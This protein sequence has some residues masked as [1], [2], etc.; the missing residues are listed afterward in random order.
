MQFSNILSAI[1][2]KRYDSEKNQTLESV[3]QFTS[4]GEGD[5]P[6]LSAL[7][8]DGDACNNGL[9]ICAQ[10]INK[11]TSGD[12][13]ETIKSRRYDRER[14]AGI[15]ILIPFVSNIISSDLPKLS[16]LYTD[17]DE[18]NNA[19]RICTKAFDKIS[20]KDLIETIKVRRYDREKTT[21]ICILTPYVFNITSSDLLQLSALYRDGDALNDGLKYCS[22]AINKI[23]SED[24]VNM[25]M[26][27]RFDREKNTCLS[28]LAPFVFNIVST[29]LKKL[30]SVYTDGDAFNAGLRFCT[31][32]IT[33][34]DP[35]DIVEI[36]KHRRYDREKNIGLSIL[37]SSLSCI[38][39]SDLGCL[40]SQ[41]SDDDQKIKAVEILYPKITNIIAQDLIDIVA[42]CRF[43]SSRSKIREIFNKLIRETVKE[44][45]K[46][47]I[48]VPVKE[49]II[50]PIKEQTKEPIGETVVN[51]G[52]V[53]EKKISIIVLLQ[54][55]NHLNDT[56]KINIL[57]QHIGSLDLSEN[58]SICE[59]LI[60][61][62]KSIKSFE[63][64]CEVLAIRPE[65]KDSIIAEA[66]KIESEKL[67][68]SANIM[69]FG[70]SFDKSLFRIN[71]T[72]SIERD[73][74]CV[75]ITRTNS[76]FDIQVYSYEG[77]SVNQTANIN[78]SVVIQRSS[79]KASS[80][81]RNSDGIIISI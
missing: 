26:S 70:T 53:I 33:K 6:K 81:I 46:E 48:K 2:A 19:L 36:V 37:V 49:P 60:K 14:T 56:E 52:A 38:T 61:H 10:V 20:P 43:D 16:A 5:L 39:S 47:S 17:G 73:G 41:Y 72:K 1:A 65:L 25:V 42:N 66:K 51:R 15:S 24:L 8:T 32:A 29:D 54:A 71:A 63:L 67:T 34:V 23:N 44:P 74:V 77:R 28:I 59:E 30:S 18:C 40:L 11:I 55:Y 7:Y 22:M 64:A 69:I 62:F 21:G 76:Y 78:E 75:Q 9:R 68:A 35:K 50:A 31:K 3:I 57:E 45:S 80:I 27:I 79:S 12:L 4:I 13:I 58:D